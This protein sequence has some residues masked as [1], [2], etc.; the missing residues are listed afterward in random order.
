M[1]IYPDLTMLNSPSCCPFFTILLSEP[2]C[3]INM[4]LNNTT[5]LH[6]FKIL[7]E[8]GAKEDAFLKAFAEPH[9]DISP[10]ANGTSGELQVLLLLECICL[11]KD[12]AIKGPLPPFMIVVE[13][14][15]KRNNTATKGLKHI[16]KKIRRYSGAETAA[17]HNNG[18]V[19]LSLI[20]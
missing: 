4:M 14:G 12:V 2:E 13:K 9:H 3:T 19:S 8:Q 16:C 10:L 20:L 5:T 11:Y 17:E 15:K 18:R 6:S 1:C 7:N